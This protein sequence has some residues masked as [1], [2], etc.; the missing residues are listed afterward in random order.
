MRL[1]RRDQVSSS[2]TAPEPTTAELLWED[3]SDLFVEEGDWAS[4]H[5]GPDVEFNDLSPEG[6]ERLWEYLRAR[7]DPIEPTVEIWHD[8]RNQSVPLVDVPDAVA[9]VQQEKIA[10]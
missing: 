8:E 5:A 10:T 6:V 4:F 7:A 3:L 2:E 1:R 9:L